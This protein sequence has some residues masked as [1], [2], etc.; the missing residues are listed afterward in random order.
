MIQIQVLT[1]GL[2][3]RAFEFEETEVWLGRSVDC[4]V[5]FDATRDDSVGR[6][7]ACIRPRRD[8]TGW[9]L[10][11]C[12]A[13]G[14]LLNGQP[15]DKPKQLSSGDVIRLAADGPQFKVTITNSL[16]D[17]G[18]FV[19][20]ANARTES[21]PRSSNH[22]FQLLLTVSAAIVMA[23]A[24][25]IIVISTRDRPDAKVGKS[26][27]K[28]GKSNGKVGKSNGKVGK[29]NGSVGESNGNGAKILELKK[30][31]RL[32]ESYDRKVALVGFK[33]KDTIVPVRGAWLVRVG[34]LASTGNLVLA[35][36]VAGKKDEA[37]IAMFENGDPKPIGSFT[38][39]PKYDTRKPEGVQSR[40]HNFSVMS[41][42]S[43]GEGL[44]IASEDELKQ[45]A[46]VGAK[47][48]V[49][50]FPHQAKGVPLSRFSRLTVLRREAQVEQIL[51]EADAKTYP[52]LH[53]RFTD[54]GAE[55][56]ASGSP[57]FNHAGRVV[58]IFSHLGEESA[59]FIVL[60]APIREMLK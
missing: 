43:I 52:R 34:K 50:G 27:A 33:I 6:R 42:E 21:A 35:F 54:R 59:T 25:V 47:V 14:T 48:M 60:I 26:I 40:L 44:P 24:V 23:S 56:I 22:V 3:G 30:T 36:Q 46:V 41:I 5:V 29:S 16:S 45:L 31:F 58:G 4:Q 13:N 1:G 28:V 49:V 53:I 18:G 9:V 11:N 51:L 20:S 10:E 8:G 17:P 57:V 7:H 2:K 37:L 39:H 15:I 55:M 19:P 38:V 32:P 12:H